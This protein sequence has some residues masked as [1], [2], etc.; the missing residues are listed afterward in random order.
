ML[1]SKIAVL[2]LSITAVQITAS[3]IVTPA[4]HLGKYAVVIGEEFE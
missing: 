4:P 1:R 3:E 2:M